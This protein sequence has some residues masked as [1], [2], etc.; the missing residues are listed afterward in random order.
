VATGQELWFRPAP[1]NILAFDVQPQGQQ[2][3]AALANGSLLFFDAGGSSDPRLI[4]AAARTPKP[5]TL[6]GPLT[7]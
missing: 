2:F 5:A 6:P 1:T 3:A 7:A 4:P